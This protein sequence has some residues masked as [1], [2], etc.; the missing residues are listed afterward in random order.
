[1]S[2]HKAAVDRRAWSVSGAKR[3]VRWNFTRNT[4]QGE[5]TV[6]ASMLMMVAQ[7]F[8]AFKY[9]GWAHSQTS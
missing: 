4:R 9:D 7:M 5:E 2:F 6:W 3:T 1:M 8:V